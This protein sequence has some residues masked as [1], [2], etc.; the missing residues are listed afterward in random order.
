MRD[1]LTVL[2]KELLERFGEWS[3]F[4][5]ALVQSSIIV[6]VLG[7]VLP[8]SREQVLVDA[9]A[10]AIS[11]FVFPQ[12]LSASVAAD[13][14][15]GERER[16]TLE[17]LLATPLPDRAIVLG[18]AA[19]AVL[20][21]GAISAVSLLLASL[22]ASG[23]RSADTLFIPSAA[24]LGGTLVAGLGSGAVIAGISIALSMYV[25]VARSGQQLMSMIA[26]FGG[27]FTFYVLSHHH[28][29]S[30]VAVLWKLDGLVCAAG[31]LLLAVATALFNRQRFFEV[32]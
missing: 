24:L 12:I 13:A 25:P 17:T 19:V 22:V 31:A 30:S 32:R 18:K 5:G 7:V 23:A 9:G 29:I 20:F 15:A 16:R 8:F 1:S 21:A 26:I 10:T 4:K 14:F 11:Y 2:R 28:V 6:A 3:S 27:S